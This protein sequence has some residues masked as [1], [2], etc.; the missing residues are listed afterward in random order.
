MT[1]IVGLLLL[2]VN[3]LMRD[4]VDDRQKDA[5]SREKRRKNMTLLLEK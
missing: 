3:E 4:V 2:D 1:I 5:A